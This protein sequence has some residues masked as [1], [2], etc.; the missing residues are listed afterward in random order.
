MSRTRISVV[1][2]RVLLYCPASKLDIILCYRYN[3]DTQSEWSPVMK[4]ALKILICLV[5]VVGLL[6]AA[7]WFFLS[8]RPDLACEFFI[9]RAEA[10]T[11]NGRY[12]RAVRYY[13]RAFSLYPENSELAIDL[14]NAYKRDDNYTKAEY[15]LVSAITANPDELQ[16]YLE[17]SKTYVE[18]DKLLDADL[19]LSRTANESIQAQLEELRPDAPVIQ[20]EGGYYTE[21]TDVSLSYSGGTAYLATDGEY[22]SLNKDLYMEPVTLEAGETTVMAIVVSEDGLVSPVATAGFTV[23]G[24]IEEAT[25]VDPAVETAIRTVLGK[26]D[27]EPV[28]TNELWALTTLELPTDAKDLSDLAACHALTSLSMHGTYGVD[29]SVLS[30]LTSL[31]TLDLSGCTVSTNGLAAIGTLSDL[32]NLNLSGCALT[33]ISSL[34]GLTNLT[35]LDLSGNALTDISSLSNLSALTDVNLSSNSITSI[36]P[37]AA[38][39]NL[40]VLDISSNQVVSLSALNNKTSL[41]S[42]S[43]AGNQIAD[44]SPLSTCTALQVLDISSNAITSLEPVAALAQLVSLSADQNAI[45]EVPDFSKAV[46]LSNF[47]ASNNALTDLSGLRGLPVLNYVNVDYNQI[48]DLSPLLECQNLVQVDAFANPVGDVSELLSHSIIVNYDPTYTAEDVS[49]AE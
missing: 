34:S 26:A 23:G 49:A 25:F 39:N 24:V 14:A 45:A 41:T 4:R 17:L 5:I 1:V 9:N 29:F 46:A 13:S 6:A 28:M 20:P 18:Q 40:Q 30:E 27:D 10:A 15:T 3:N 19:M 47:S 21:Y 36:E 33:N 8:Y 44:L 7:A 35:T 22:P 38:A 37:L 12:D 43:A 42:L 48:S 2:I 32:K 11:A 31:E 16:L